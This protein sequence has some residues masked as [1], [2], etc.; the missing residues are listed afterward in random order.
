MPENSEQGKAQVIEDNRV[1]D[2]KDEEEQGLEE[3]VES[4]YICGAKVS[5]IKDEKRQSQANT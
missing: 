2:V 1:T 5:I 4:V 3:D